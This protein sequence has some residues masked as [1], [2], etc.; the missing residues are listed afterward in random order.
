MERRGG[1]GFALSNPYPDQVDIL[2]RVRSKLGCYSPATCKTFND[3]GL[4]PF[5]HA[6]DNPSENTHTLCFG[7]IS[8]KLSGSRL[9]LFVSKRVL[10]QTDSGP[11]V[12]REYFRSFELNGKLAKKKSGIAKLTYL[13]L[14]SRASTSI[15]VNSTSREICFTSSKFNNCNLINLT[16]YNVSIVDMFGNEIFEATNIPESACQTVNQLDLLPQCGP[17]RMSTQP[18]ND[19]I[20]YNPDIRQ[21]TSG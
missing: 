15:S 4:V 6:C 16:Q 8:E 19:Y 1:L 9:D 20:V 18:F 11:Y 14:V 17:F 5:F 10:C 3:S 13:V 21:I 7:N 2:C 12:A